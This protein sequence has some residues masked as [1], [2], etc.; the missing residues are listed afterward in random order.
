[1]SLVED[2]QRVMDRTVRTSDVFGKRG[3]ICH[4]CSSARI[5]WNDQPIEHSPD[6]PVPALPGIVAALAAAERL[7]EILGAEG[8]TRDI[9][10]TRVCRGCQVD[11]ALSYHRHRTDCPWQVLVAA[12][13]GVEVTA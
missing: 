11:M 2:A 1:M 8:P 10:A 7:R 9:G 3:T 13:R 4:L 12:L 6:C 5:F